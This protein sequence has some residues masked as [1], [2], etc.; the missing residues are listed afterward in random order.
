MTTLPFDDSQSHLQDL[1]STA[2][3]VPWHRQ[4]PELV[5]EA[6][7]L[8]LQV[9]P[10]LSALARLVIPRMPRCLLATSSLKTELASSA[11]A[12]LDDAVTHEHFAVRTRHHAHAIAID[13]DHA[14]WVE[15]LEDLSGYGVPRPTWVCADPW[16][17]RAHLVW[18][19]RD[20]VLLTSNGREAPQRLHRVVA[21]LL[22]VAL[23]AD[24][25]YTGLLTRNPWRL[26]PPS[27]RSGSPGIPVLWD[28]HMASAP[29]LRH[30]VCP[31]PA[32]HDLSD[33]RVPLRAWQDATDTPSLCRRRRPQDM[34][35][36]A[37]RGRRLFDAL[38]RCVYEAWPLS[39]AAVQALAAETAAALGSPI[40]ARQLVAMARRISN[41]MKTRYTGRQPK[42]AGAP[43][44]GRDCRLTGA[45]ALSEKQ[46]IAGRRTASGRRGESFDRLRAAVD[47]LRTADH[48]VTRASLARE[49]GLSERTV[50]RLWA[51]PEGRQTLS[52][53]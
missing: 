12:L 39:E 49:A 25:A 10:H 35:A 23:R 18:W 9:A 26:G 41:W 20:P 2:D 34:D 37:D 51:T 47:R 40:S 42:K 1:R 13:C 11:L 7:K 36:D 19:L 50:Q 45:L 21:S 24:N 29:G 14:G 8:A 30:A 28:A 38:R 48:P 27:A 15:G 31:V 46:A 53:R 33:F 43:I 52:I 6:L 22:T 4:R 17:G 32:L 3:L 16:S 44:P 5:L